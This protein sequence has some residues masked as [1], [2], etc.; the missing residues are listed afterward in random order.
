MRKLKC[1]IATLGLVVSLS[2][3][4]TA[5]EIQAPTGCSSPSPVAGETQ[6]PSVT[7]PGEIQMPT[8]LNAE[9]LSIGETLLL[10]VL[11]TIF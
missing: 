5:G 4:T 7:E 11:L 1:L 3:A 10:K 9:D 2:T 8:A 6:G